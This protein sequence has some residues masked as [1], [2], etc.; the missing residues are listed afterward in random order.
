MSETDGLLKRYDIYGDASDIKET[1]DQIVDLYNDQ[2]SE[3][4]I[5]DIEKEI[6]AS[7][8]PDDIYNAIDQSY[9]GES[10]DKKK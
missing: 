9:L 6:D 4:V 3:E 1:R 2:R 5:E 10:Q 8:H 7:N